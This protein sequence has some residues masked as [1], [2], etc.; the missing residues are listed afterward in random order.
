MPKAAE[1]AAALAH[2]RRPE[3]ELPKCP[4]GR[5]RA[6]PGPHT[7]IHEHPETD[8]M[9]SDPSRKTS[10][11]KTEETAAPP[12]RR[13]I[14]GF[15]L[16]VAGALGAS[17][18]FLWPALRQNMREVPDGALSVTISMSGFAPNTLVAR[19]GQRIDLQLVNPDNA[20]HT[21][22]GGWHQFAIDEL[23]LDVLVAPLSEERVSFT[24]DTPGI[25][26]FYC[27]VCCGGQANPYMHG[28]LTVE[29]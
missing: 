10:E 5:S 4:S 2:V 8:K 19:A 12:N 14:L 25:Y 20:L 3:M 16:V 21:D 13:N 6:R 24:V 18:Y 7:H 17:G 1:R 23:E 27:G 26:D 9:R 11:Q 22:G 29:A 15:G 28:R